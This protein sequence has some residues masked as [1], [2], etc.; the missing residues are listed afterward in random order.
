[1]KLLFSFT[2]ALSI[3]FSPIMA[4]AIALKDYPARPK[5]IVVLVIDQFRS[6]YLTRYQSRFL[7]AGTPAA[8]GGFRFLTQGAWLPFAEYDVMQSMTCPG[9][10]MILSGARP[11]A[12][13]F[14]TNDW[15]D[16]ATKKL[17][18]CAHDP[19][20]G[21]S[22][23]RLRTTTLGD[24]LKNVRPKSQVIALALKDR[25]AIMLGG[26]RANAAVWVDGKTKQW[27]TSTYYG[28][29]PAWAAELNAT[30]GKAPIPNF[31]EVTVEA[32]SAGAAWTLDGALKAFRAQKLGRNGET[33]I[34]AVSLSTHDV[35][36]HA[37]GPNASELEKLTVN[38][39][40]LIANFLR[41]I[42]K[43]MGGL[44][45]VWIVL[46][47]DHGAPAAP[48]EYAKTGIQSGRFDYLAMFKKINQRLDDKY[49]AVKD[50]WI[51]GTRLFHFFLNQEAITKKKLSVREV[52]NEI[53][54]VML[55]EPGVHEVFTRG[56]HL[57]RTYPAGMLGEQIRNSY[58][59]GQSGDLVLIPRPFFLESS[60]SLKT[61]HITGWSYDRMV[62]LIL[63]GKSFK[64]GVYPGGKVIDL[65]PT[66][67]FALGIL[68]PTMSEGRVLSE[69]L[70]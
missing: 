1:M 22:P 58:I 44:N 23:R 38:E 64:G 28:Q 13:G 40:R 2:A 68:P 45:D 17:I 57:A 61:T 7:P 46:T 37:L 47:A 10:A 16:P 52:E 48:E 27:T 60:R 19:V 51:S 18:Y 25:S 54:T 66:L 34:L 33:D 6:D 36:G 42:S 12:F 11:A 35:M 55:Q 5:L 21:L 41:D 14:A 69:A 15:F 9:H 24:E 39:D 20:D 32:A 8:P 56:D 30:S 59:D 43:D 63:W 67:A 70:K 29:L 50:G 62:P 3:F 53:R 31:D 65:A 26:H 49:G 4:S